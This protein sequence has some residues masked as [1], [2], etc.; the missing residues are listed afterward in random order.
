MSFRKL[1]ENINSEKRGTKEDRTTSVIRSGIG[2][3]DNFWEDFI[4]ILNNSEGLSELLDVPTTKISE[5][6]ERIS[7]ALEKVNQI[8][9]EQKPMDNVKLL[10]T[11][12]FDMPEPETVSEK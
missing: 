1:W 11:G 7:K 9:G 12:D 2:I 10:K 8:D 3:R 5:W 4:S 6:H